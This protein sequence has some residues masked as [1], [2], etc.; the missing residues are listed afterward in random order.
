M[1]IMLRP[2]DR[3]L[4]PGEPYPLGATW[5]EEEDGTNFAIFSENAT[6]IELLLYS[7]SKQ[8]YPKEVIEVKNRTGDIW[9]VFVPGVGPRQ[10]YAYRVYGPYKPEEGLRFN[11]N[12]VLIDPYCKAINGTLIWDDSVF[13]Y[14]IGDPNQDLSFDERPDDKFV[15]KCVIIDPYFEWDDE[16]FFMKKKIPWNKTIIYET[17]VKGFTKLRKDL[18]E[19]IRGTYRGLAS[20]SMIV[21]LKYLGV[22]TV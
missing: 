6:K 5:I 19:N 12:K 13:G 2:R 9:H 10:L 14:K 1:Y 15:P 3:P 18:P 7:P 8:D 16:H 22:T 17:H 4:R 20:D 11:P 21:Y